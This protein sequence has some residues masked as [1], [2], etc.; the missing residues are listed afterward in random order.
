L[1]DKGF[2]SEEHLAVIRRALE[3]EAAYSALMNVLD[4]LEAIIQEAKLRKCCCFSSTVDHGSLTV[5][6]RFQNYEGGDFRKSMSFAKAYERIG[7]PFVPDTATSLKLA[8]D[9]LVLNCE[10]MVAMS[11]I[12]RR[13]S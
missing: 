13:R 3:D 2:F 10:G 1:P 8:I 7:R 5:R 9:S 11:R 12:Y 6:L 4:R